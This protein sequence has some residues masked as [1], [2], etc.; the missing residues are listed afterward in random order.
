MTESG[1]LERAIT[2][3]ALVPPG[4]RGVVLLSGGADSVGLLWGLT[5]LLAP[6]A[7]TALHVNYGLRADASHDEETCRDLSDR[8]GV[9]LNVIR[10][11]EREGNLHDWARTVRYHEAE[12]IAG[13]LGLDWIA[14]GHTRTD[15]VETVLY[16][17]ASSPG[18]RAL[19]P[20]PARRGRI[21][22]PLLGLGRNEVRGQVERAGLPF[23]D[24]PSNLDLS[25][26]R[27]KIRTRV[28]PALGE[29][30]PAF[31]RNIARSIEELEEEA[32]F[33]E[34][35]GSALIREGL[36]SR[37]CIDAD[38]IAG[39]APAVARH[40]LRLLIER[41]TGRAAPVSIETAALVRR[42]AG[43]PEG[44]SADPGGGVMIEVGSGVVLAE[45]ADPATTE[46]ERPSGRLPIPGALG[47]DGW[48]FGA[49]DTGRHDPVDGPETAT[50]DRARLDEAVE[51]RAWR[52]GD[53]IRPLGM[54][55]SR[56]VADLMAERRLPRPRRPEWP[57]VESG[58]EIAWVPGV[59][60]SETF[61]AHRA[62][63]DPILLTAEPPGPAGD[64]TDT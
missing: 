51:V 12:R 50:L 25:F 34:A 5:A 48:L 55:G 60:V 37:P 38:A 18:T 7:V 1:V 21:V 30:N 36:D 53:R 59:A 42:L 58:G 54:G 4:S 17:L 32:A 56:A 10:A 13:R 19:R 57:V 29:V 22:R 3:S 52:P 20:M 40:G 14:V 64:G 2:G 9:E 39:A 11:G 35:A 8:L 62:T 46:P 24:D 23:V 63:G 49:E 45:R 15:L 26:A 41:A 33:L 43:R 44:G 28:M 27:A 6:G 31:E 47:W 61:R 16:R